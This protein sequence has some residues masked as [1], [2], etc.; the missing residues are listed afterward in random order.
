MATYAASRNVA[1]TIGVEN[2]FDNFADK[3]KLV[4]ARNN[5]PPVSDWRA[6]RQ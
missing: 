5:R 6:L 2:V 1:V 4:D 3:L